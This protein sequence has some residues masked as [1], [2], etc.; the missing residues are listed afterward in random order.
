MQWTPTTAWIDECVFMLVFV[1]IGIIRSIWYNVSICYTNMYPLKH[2]HVCLLTL[3]LI[4]ILVLTL[5]I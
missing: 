2:T 4:F 5:T 3:L 1:P